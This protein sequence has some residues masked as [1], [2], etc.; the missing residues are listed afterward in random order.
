[1]Y[2]KQEIFL[3]EDIEEIMIICQKYYHHITLVIKN[4]PQYILNK[5]NFKSNK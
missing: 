2:Y 3:L 1:M 4:F 5:Y